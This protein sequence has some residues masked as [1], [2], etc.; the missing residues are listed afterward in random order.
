MACLS[1]LHFRQAGV[2][3][4]IWAMI[5]QGK[6]KGKARDEGTEE[7]AP[8]RRLKPVPSFFR[9]FTHLVQNAAV[10]DS[11]VAPETLAAVGVGAAQLALMLP[12]RD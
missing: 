1:D 10:V 4:R 3:I 12:R 8:Q 9:Q 2:A 6:K 5:L 7:A 11:I